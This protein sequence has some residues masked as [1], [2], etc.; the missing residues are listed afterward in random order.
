VRGAQNAA[1]IERD[2]GDTELVLGT[3]AGRW[4]TAEAVF[5]DLLDLAREKE[6]ARVA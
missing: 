2:G 6:V 1:I 5:A 4:P 3:G